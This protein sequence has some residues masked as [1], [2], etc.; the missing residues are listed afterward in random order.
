MRKIILLFALFFFVVGTV[1]LY[2]I[3]KRGQVAWPEGWNYFQLISESMA[4]HKP[5]ENILEIDAT[6][7]TKESKK[8]LEEQAPYQLKKMYVHFFWVIV[9]LELM[10]AMMYVV[11]SIALLRMYPI[12][13]LLVL[14]TLLLELWMK[15]AVV[16][17]EKMIS[18]PLKAVFKNHSII[19]AY[20]LPNLHWTSAYSLYTSGLDF[21]LPMGQRFLGC[22]LVFLVFTFYLFSKDSMV[23]T[24]GR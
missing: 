7:K 15:I 11:S 2:S 22:Y 4:R 6:V 23:K 3:Y 16:C 24:F 9:V 14:W 1:W 17:Y 20:F 18:I 21:L 8:F 12:G 13:R 5:V 19:D 10:V